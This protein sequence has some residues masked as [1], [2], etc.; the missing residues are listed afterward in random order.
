M[1][2]PHEHDFWLTLGGEYRCTFPGCGATK[3]PGRQQPPAADLSVLEQVTVDRFGI[4]DEEVDDA[5][6]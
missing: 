2:E 1:V 6:I 4:F 3:Q 5:R